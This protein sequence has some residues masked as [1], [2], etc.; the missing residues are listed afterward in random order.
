MDVQL[1]AGE[2]F[3]DMEVTL[4]RGDIE[5]RLPGDA[6]FTLGRGHRSR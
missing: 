2:S 4:G 6:K 1:S 5:L 3:G